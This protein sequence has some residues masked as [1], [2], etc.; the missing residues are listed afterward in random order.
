[1]GS[2]A[3][4]YQFGRGMGTGCL[5][6]SRRRAGAGLGASQRGRAQV[7][8]RPQVTVSLLYHSSD[9]DR[10]GQLASLLGTAGVT[11]VPWSGA[12]IDG[13]VVFLSPAGLE[14]PG[15][16]DQAAAVPRL[17][18]VRVGQIDSGQV[19][20]RLTTLNWIDWQQDNARSTFGYVLAALLSD[21]ARRDLS[22]QLSHEAEAW[23]RSG[24]R[25]ELLIADY[26]RARGMASVIDDLEADQL[27]APSATMREFVRR[28]VTVSRP[29]Y[30]RRRWRLVL[31]AGGIITALATV[32]VAFPAIQVSRYNNHEAIVTTGDP[33]TLQDL[34]EWSAANAAAL[35]VD[36]TPAEKA[37]AQVTLLR[38][39]N[40]PWELDA[41]QWRSSPYSSVPFQHGKLAIVSV[42]AELA[43]LNVMT[44]RVLWHVPD[45]GGPYSLSVDPAGSTAV[46]LSAHGAIVINLARHTWRPV[47]AGTRFADGELGSDGVGVVRLDGAHLA[48]LTMATG[49]VTRLGTY[50]AI[51]SVAA[52]TPR[53]SAAALVR[54]GGGRVELLALPSR[55]V[56]A[57]VPASGNPSSEIGGISPDGRHAL[58][59]GRDDQFW[60][61]GA[62]QAAKATGIAVPAVPSGLNWDTGDRVV[63]YSQDKR[64]QVYYLP[65]AELL[66]TICREDPRLYDIVRDD[67]SDVVACEDPGGTTFWRLP[68]GPLTRRV[69]GE[70]ASR[71]M[72]ASG[73]RV[74]SSGPD[75]QIRG[76][77]LRI[78]WGQVLSSDISAVD[79]SGNG[80]NVV[81]GD[82]VG[83]VAV[84][85]LER[86]YAARV[87]VW[88]DP[89]SSPIAAVGW[90]QGPVAVTRSG[91]TWKL[92]DC[93]DCGTVAGLIRAYR[94][95]VTGCF[96][97]RQLQNI[98]S[99]VWAVL[100]LRECDAPFGQPGS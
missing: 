18:P 13:V 15:W 37:L 95:R 68:A 79:I 3:L 84:L 47:A 91:Q 45:P 27:A 12:E 88:S 83:E 32:A 38:A 59:A 9:A 34:P 81:V 39:L 19:P 41:L 62:G 63:I 92:T 100:G 7:A 89:D 14:E 70:S 66:G 97:A 52:R 20:K 17:V 31:G 28:S 85:D 40:S 67:S 96:T 82:T 78:S 75:I 94:A 8:H 80:Q 98:S 54:D 23:H 42:G 56:I 87:V 74:S 76:P 93:T 6:M 44:Q 57:S 64:G 35:L 30:R 53:G 71:S 65:R 36:G 99:R 69:P 1:M 58:V 55:A 86:G 29:R 2:S 46:G 77:G 26:R 25:D 51:I 43:V 61:F 16:L 11:V 72:T 10:A 24:R 90:D 5:L 33:Y 73:V 48:E 4:N 60:A 50:P 22:R 49:T 21:P